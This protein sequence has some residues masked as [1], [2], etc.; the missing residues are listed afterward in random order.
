MGPE[1]WN[2]DDDLTTLK[3]YL[4][5]V[6]I[7]PKF[8]RLGSEVKLLRQEAEY[9]CQS[10]ELTLAGNVGLRNGILNGTAGFTD[11]AYWSFETLRIIACIKYTRVTILNAGG[12]SR[13]EVDNEKVVKPMIGN[14]LDWCA[15]RVNQS[16]KGVTLGDFMKRKRGEDINQPGTPPPSGTRHLDSATQWEGKGWECGEC[17]A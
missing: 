9:D 7:V 10:V 17:R 1:V 2:E 5:N 3:G 8:V 11:G 14:I 4:K 16:K 15:A 13:W 6:K 12:D